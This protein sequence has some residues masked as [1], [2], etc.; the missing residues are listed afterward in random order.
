MDSVIEYIFWGVLYM[1]LITSIIA[2]IVIVRTLVKEH[3]YH[4]NK[5]S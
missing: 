5:N 3:K 4:R 1:A 2:I